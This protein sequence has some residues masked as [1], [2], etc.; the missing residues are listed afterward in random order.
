MNKK[1]LLNRIFVGIG[2]AIVMV[3]MIVMAAFSC[4]N[5][6][7]DA[8]YAFLRV[9]DA[10]IISVLSLMAVI[11]MR[12]ALGKDRIPD[13]FSW[14]IW[15]YGFGIGPAY[16][17]FGFSGVLFLLLLIFAISSITAMKINRADCLINIAFI[18]V[19]PG[20]FMSSML[21]IN[22]CAATQDITQ[23]SNYEQIKDYI[24]SDIWSITGI[25]RQSQL[26]PYNAIGLAFVFA[27]S[28][29]TDV[30]A[31]FVGVLFGKRKLCPEISPKKTVEGAIGGVFGGLLGSFAVYLI[32]DYFHLFG[33]A[34][35]L[36]IHGLSKF[37]YVLAY[38]VIGLGGSIMT[39]L[40]DL[41]ASLIKRQCGIKDYSR[42]LGEHGGIIDRFDGIMLNASFVATVYMFII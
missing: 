37:N 26:L 2:I 29:L 12:R 41:L 40:G 38:V 15:A 13:N 42:V 36:G 4:D 5:R 21:Y 18:L 14:I 22:K 7:G 31:F 24:I 8:K 25:P 23:L 19:Y 9:I 10:A 28:T 30:F 1:S 27:V 33:E 11:E 6:N 16:L 34:L 39:Q 32:F 17:L 3:G 20:L 35:G